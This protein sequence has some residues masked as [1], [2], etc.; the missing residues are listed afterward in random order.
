MRELTD[1]ADLPTSMIFGDGAGAALVGACDTGGIGPVVWGG[2]GRKGDLVVIPDRAGHITMK[3]QGVF[4]WAIT[5]LPPVAREACRRAGI[6]PAQVAAFV[7]HQANARIVE[8][9]GRSLGLHD[10]CVVHAIADCGNTSAASIPLALSSLKEQEVLE[11]GSPVLLL[12]FG[13]GLSYAA[14]VVSL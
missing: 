7:P 6:T 8:H 10:A 9:L 14:Q 2:D 5:T 13:A 1:P 4:R 12:G 11:E 3:G